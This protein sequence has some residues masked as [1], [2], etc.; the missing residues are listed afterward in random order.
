MGSNRDK[1]E[2]TNNVFNTHNDPKFLFSLEE[3]IDIE[4]GH[5]IL[6]PFHLICS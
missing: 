6:R 1:M 4:L 3:S 5:F 2:A